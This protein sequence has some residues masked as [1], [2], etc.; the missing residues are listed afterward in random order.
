MSESTPAPKPHPVP[1]PIPRPRPATPQPAGTPTP[2]DEAAAARAAAWGRVDDDGNVWLRSG[3]GERIV[4]QYAAGGSAEDALSLYVR[5]YLDLEAQVTLLTTRIEHISPEEASA[6]LKALDEQLV[7]PAVVGDVDALRTRVASLCERISSR[8]E[9]LNAQREEA[10]AQ[11][12]AERTQLVERAEAIAAADPDKIHWRN[13]RDELGQIFEQWKA[14]QKA[15]PRIDRPTE[16]ALWKRFSRARTQFD[17]MRRQHFAALE[18]Q[19]SEVT[20]RKN[21]L[22]ERAEAL[23]ASTNWNATAAEFRQLMDEWRQA[24]RTTRK[25]DD[26]LWE[27]FH[28]AQQAFFDARSAHFSARDEEFNENLAAKLALVAEAEKILPVRDPEAARATLRDIED[29]WDAIGMVPRGDINRTEG[30]LREIEDAVRAAENERWRRTDPEK[31][32]R[33]DGMAAQL[34]K[35][36]ADLDEEIAAAQ[37]AGDTKQVAQLEENKKARQAWLDQVTKDL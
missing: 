9:Q 14:A 11:A 30:R 3:D 20:A 35:L 33:S 24:G 1:R 5:R 15:G 18:T 19:R 23:S 12:L 22:I 37:A 21:A 27:R 10:R 8:R 31:Q 25:D 26:K 28:R 4:G 34:Q 6:S 17:R 29:R 16:E 32:Q 36:I 13:S 7:N 2:L